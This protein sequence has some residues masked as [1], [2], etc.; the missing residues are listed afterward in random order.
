MSIKKQEEINELNRST[1]IDEEINTLE[2]INARSRTF[3]VE[4]E[5]LFTSTMGDRISFSLTDMMLILLFYAKLKEI[6]ARYFAQINILVLNSIIDSILRNHNMLYVL[7]GIPFIELSGTQI[8][9]ILYNNVVG[10]TVTQ[11]LN[12]RQADFLSRVQN[13][14]KYSALK[15]ENVSKASL[16]IGNMVYNEDRYKSGGLGGRI[17]S[18]YRTELTRTRTLAKI[19]AQDELSQRFNVEKRWKYTWEARQP[20]LHHVASNGKK[21]DEDGFFNIEGMETPGPGLFGIPSEDINCRC[22]T[23]II[24]KQS[25]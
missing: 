24:I 19:S 9:G 21:A 10:M 2:L 17:G 23:E 4:V 16:Q 13:T 1:N 18:I 22:D 8:Q 7:A 5:Q 3:K 20:R 15:N 25:T 6:T 11:Q 12:A 14:V